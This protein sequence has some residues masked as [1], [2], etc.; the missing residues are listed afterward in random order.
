MKKLMQKVRKKWYSAG[1]KAGYESGLVVGEAMAKGEAQYHQD[2]VMKR[3][4]DYYDR[5]LAGNPDH[6]LVM[7]F[8]EHMAVADGKFMKK[9]WESKARLIKRENK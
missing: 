9:D 6:E 8:H 3:R 7:L 2:Q 5:F 1:Y 4:Q